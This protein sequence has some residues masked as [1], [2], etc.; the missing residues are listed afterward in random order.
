MQYKWLILRFIN[1]IVLIPLSFAKLVADALLVV[2]STF[3]RSHSLL[4]SQINL[5]KYG[6]WC[7]I[8]QGWKLEKSSCKRRYQVILT[9][10]TYNIVSSRSKSQLV[11]KV[12]RFRW[13]FARI[14]EILNQYD[15]E[16]FSFL[17]SKTKEVWSLK[18]FAAC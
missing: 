1:C 12:F 8:F 3:S 18:K 6:T 9:I 10:S 17:A 16:N 14:H 13:T 4:W 2:W 11:A 7:L 5:Y 15:A